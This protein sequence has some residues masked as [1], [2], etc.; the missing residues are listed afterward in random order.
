MYLLQWTM[1]AKGSKKKKVSVQN[2]LRW[3]YVFTSEDNQR[4]EPINCRT[5]QE[6]AAKGYQIK[7]LDLQFNEIS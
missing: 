2:V 5:T 6:G 3:S 7:K 4:V 1:Q